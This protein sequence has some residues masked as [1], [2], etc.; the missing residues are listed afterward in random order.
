MQRRGGNGPNTLEVLSQLIK[1][2]GDDLKLML[3]SVLPNENS[4]DVAQVKDSLG[5]G[6]D[7]STCIY[8]SEHTKAA[9]SYIIRSQASGSRTIV[10]YNALPEMTSSEFT[11]VI[12]RTDLDD[13]SWIH[14]EG[15]IPSV[16]L[17][18]IQ[19]IRSTHPSATISVEIEKP[20]R[21]GLRDLA[22]AADVSFYSRSWAQHEGY[23][24]GKECLD[25][26]AKLHSNPE[27]AFCTW[28]SEPAYALD[29]KAM[30]WQGRHPDMIPDHKVQ[31]SVGA[32]DTFI[33]GVL[34]TLLCRKDL[35]TGEALWLGVKLASA[36]VVQDGLGGL[37][38]AFA[39]FLAST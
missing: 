5:N 20:G 12:N 17:E 35:D 39:G 19:S 10:N 15:R 28:S 30:M 22:A 16:T 26:Q 4:E 6:V 29:R 7:L 2:Q 8:R 34:Y 21:P 37:G 36:K 14:F 33:A 31:D 25:A 3:C 13:L 23:T 1:H 24:D 18:C 32:G 11:E 9:S 27:L 38:E